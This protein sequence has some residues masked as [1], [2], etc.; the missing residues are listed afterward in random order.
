MRARISV[1]LLVLAMVCSGVG[2]AVGR[3][4]GRNAELHAWYQEL[5]AE[6]FGGSLPDMEVRWA[7]LAADRLGETDG[8]EIRLDPEKVTSEPQ[9]HDVLNHEACHI[10]VGIKH[11]HDGTWAVCME[12]FR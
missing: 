6:K 7:K 1:S 5:N 4:R 10:A 8:E 3:E 2:Y 9:A 12:R 11:E